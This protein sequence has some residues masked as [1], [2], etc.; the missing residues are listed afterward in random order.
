MQSDEELLKEVEQLK[1]MTVQLAIMHD[2]EALAHT[3]Q[4]VRDRLC[5]MVS[6]IWDR[7]EDDLLMVEQRK[8][9]KFRY[10]R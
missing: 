8:H 6:M 10:K 7:I 4:E 3:T 1:N 9:E 5:C 2:Y